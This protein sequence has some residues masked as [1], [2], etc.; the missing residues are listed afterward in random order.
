MPCR[1]TLPSP[2]E[3][4]PVGLS[5]PRSR[6]TNPHGSGVLGR[7]DIHKKITALTPQ[8]GRGRPRGQRS[9]R[10]NVFLDG[11]FAFGMDA[12]VAAR[13]GLRVGL[14]LTEA[15]VERLRGEDEGAGY[16]N[17]ALRF[18]SF[19]PRSAAEIERYLRGRGADD[20]AVAGILERLGRA[21]L[22]DDEA[23][24]RYWIE[25]RAAFSPR[26]ARSLQAELRAKGVDR[27]QVDEVL[28]ESEENGEG[29]EERAY[30]AGQKR[31]RLLARLDED[32]FRRRMYAFL[33]RRG[34]DYETARSTTERLWS[35]RES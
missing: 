15:D 2:L 29:E 31:L 28:E 32:E 19:R 3:G 22:V 12:E 1:A 6:E 20:T 18:L 23:F 17:D 14:A 33:Q 7:I 30:A 21:K 34:F 13:A 16:Y 5:A 25:N 35:E 26:G 4:E 8:Q 9:E 11:E 27:A 24:A 10:L